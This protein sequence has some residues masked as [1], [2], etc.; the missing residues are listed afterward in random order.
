M[1]MHIHT[2]KHTCTYIH[3]H[4]AA[5]TEFTVLGSADSPQ[6]EVAL[7]PDVAEATD[8]LVRGWA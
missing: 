5:P 1:H 7:L 8:M 4:A 2:H 3:T 6:L